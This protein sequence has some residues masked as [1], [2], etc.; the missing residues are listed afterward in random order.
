MYLVTTLHFVLL[1]TLCSWLPIIFLLFYYFYF[2][3][4][5]STTLHFG[6]VLG[7]AKIWETLHMLF[8]V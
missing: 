6:S 3:Y 4:P 1:V 7:M 8:E 5:Q 2:L